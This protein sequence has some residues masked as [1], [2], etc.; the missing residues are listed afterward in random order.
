MGLIVKNFESQ[1]SLTKR[2]SIPA[3]ENAHLHLSVLTSFP[4]GAMVPQGLGAPMVSL[5]NEN[6]VESIR[7]IFGAAHAMLVLSPGADALQKPAIGR[8]RDRPC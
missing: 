6:L 8:R 7:G 2:D 4:R 5:L 1:S 3:V